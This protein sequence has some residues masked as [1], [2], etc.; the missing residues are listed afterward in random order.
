VQSALRPWLE[1]QIIP[2]K[3]ASQ[4][5][6]RQSPVSS[7]QSASVW[8]RCPQRTQPSPWGRHRSPQLLVPCAEAGRTPKTDAATAV[9]SR[10]SRRRR[11]SLLPR[12]LVK[13]S[14]GSSTAP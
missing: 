6:Q 7:A 14:K 5:H 4:R 2:L 10:P 11:G 13:S 12:A 8:Q 1:R 3:L 9:T